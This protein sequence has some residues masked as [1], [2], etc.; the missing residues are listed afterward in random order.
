LV[1][2]SGTGMGGSANILNLSNGGQDRITELRAEDTRQ[3][4]HFGHSV[5]LDDGIALVS[6][7]GRD[8][9][10]LFELTGDKWNEVEVL[11]GF[12]FGSSV[13]LLGNVALIGGRGPAILFE[14][15][16]DGWHETSRLTLRD[17]ETVQVAL[18]GNRALV[19]G[20]HDISVF[21][22][23]ECS[24]PLWGLMLVAVLARRALTAPGTA[25]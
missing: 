13:S 20:G 2:M 17:S 25:Q 10:Y 15:A 7:P 18:D 8:A 6:A 23:P 19:A 12:G 1:G 22:V 11:R 5:D 14:R 9:V 3:G 24:P 21:V 16:P 4:D